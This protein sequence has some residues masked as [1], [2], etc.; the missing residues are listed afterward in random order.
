MAH[1]DEALDFVTKYKGCKVNILR[2]SPYFPSDAQRYIQDLKENQT[3]LNNVEN[4][5]DN[6][7]ESSTSDQSEEE[8][9]EEEKDEIYPSLERIISPLRHFY[10]I[11]EEQSLILRK[12]RNLKIKRNET[13]K[14]FNI[15]YRN[16]YSKLNKNKKK[17]ITVLDYIDSLQPNY[18]AWKMVSLRGEDITLEKAFLIAEKVDRLNSAQLDNNNRNSSPRMNNNVKGPRFGSPTKG[19]WNRPDKKNRED[20]TCFFCKEKGHYQS[21]C[22]KLKL[23]VN[24]NNKET[25]EG[26]EGLKQPLNH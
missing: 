24:S 26:S 17:V 7:E 3:E 4:N 12:I 8:D 19:M 2:M 6:S 11:A 10:D 16:L 20:I 23:T 22:P 14:D 18:E 21:E 25:T 5:E 9:K 13:I 15:R 1:G